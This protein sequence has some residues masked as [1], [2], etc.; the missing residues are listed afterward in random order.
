M[1]DTPIHYKT[2]TEVAALIEARELSPVEVTNSMLERIDALDGHLKSYATVMSEH[3]V[4]SAQ[5]A[6]S[7]IEAGEYKGP[8]HGV[9][10]AVKDLVL[11][12]RGSDDGRR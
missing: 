3:A 9:P 1:K 5:K 7:E 6:E 2:I 10:I 8:L 12:E 4:A 11:H